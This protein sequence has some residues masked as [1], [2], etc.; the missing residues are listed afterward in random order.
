MRTCGIEKLFLMKESDL[1]R[2]LTPKK[3]TTVTWIVMNVS[4]GTACMAK[5]P[6]ATLGPETAEK[7]ALRS[8]LLLYHA[9]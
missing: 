5:V 2:L 9:Y 8:A 1:G 4:A 7:T 3:S 6:T